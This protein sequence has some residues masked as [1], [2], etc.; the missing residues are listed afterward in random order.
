MS[1]I[2]WLVLDGVGVGHAPDAAAFGDQGADT[3]GHVVSAVPKLRLPWLTALGIGRLYGG[4]NRTLG[5]WGRM[6][7]RSL[8]KDT[9]T[10]HWEMTGVVRTTPF[11]TYPQ[12]F[13]KE[14]I[15][16]FELETGRG[17]LGNMPASGTEIIEA[18]GD[19]QVA[20]GKW[21]VY[22]S[23]DSVFQIAAHVDVIAL[24]E[25]YAA[26]EKARKMLTGHHAVARVIARPFK[27]NSGHYVRTV[28]RRDYS[29]EPPYPML[30]DELKN[31]GVPVCGVGKIHDIFCGRG[32]SR[33]LL[34]H[35]NS[36]GIQATLQAMKEQKDG[37]IFTNLVDF[38]MLYGHRRDV[39]GFARGLS[40]ADA[41]IGKIISSMK[42]D[43]VL[44]ICA[45]HGC[46]PTHAGSD[47]TRED[48]PVLL[49]GRGVPSDWALPTADGFGCLGATC[50][51]ILGVAYSGEG[52]SYN[53]GK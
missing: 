44:M 10:G 33:T 8:G 46:D 3:F 11:P 23:A 22:T 53:L 29:L 16:R 13:P 2:I 4:S 39:A 7:E 18:L 49:Y 14:I 42:S 20:T 30:L 21:I 12:G 5:A 51:S 27:G 25:L 43:D 40:E 41:G 6:R 38:D 52:Q 19:K 37:L 1:R 34:S 17:V 45:D 36:E 24:D 9:T 48:V 15:H 47:H 26:C 50:A 31:A 28:D 35:S 32:I